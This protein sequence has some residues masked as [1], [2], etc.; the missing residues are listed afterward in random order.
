MTHVSL[1]NQNDSVKQFVLSLSQ[2]RQGAV[3]ELDGKEVLRVLPAQHQRS[4]PDEAWT[5]AKNH[6][7]CDLIDKKI[8][9]GLDADEEIELADLQQQMLRYR[10]R[11]APL[12]LEYARRLHQDLL[13]RAGS[14]STDVEQ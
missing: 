8:D 7:R 13:K 10:D 4:Q 12:P 9:S 11:V 5:D 1:D 6:R 3:V 2:D 14:D